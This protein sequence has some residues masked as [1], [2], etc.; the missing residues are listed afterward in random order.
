VVIASINSGVN[1][2]S[3][4]ALVRGWQWYHGT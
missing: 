3:L 4:I 1:S 2:G